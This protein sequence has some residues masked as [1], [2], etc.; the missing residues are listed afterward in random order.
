MNNIRTKIKILPNF[1]KKYNIFFHQM[2]KEELYA[3]E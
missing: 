2:R 1:V 3:K